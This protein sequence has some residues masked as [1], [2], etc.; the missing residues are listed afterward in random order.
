MTANNINKHAEKIFS[1]QG[2]HQVSSAKQA[3]ELM[4][5]FRREA[6]QKIIR[7][8]GAEAQIETSK[9]LTNHSH[10]LAVMKETINLLLKHNIDQA[11]LQAEAQRLR[12]VIDA[13]RFRQNMIFT[14]IAAATGVISIL[15]QYNS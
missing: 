14:I 1:L 15:L 10:D 8:K 12:E 2:S 13:R 4:D 7:Q 6:E 9:T 3:S 5:L 11:L